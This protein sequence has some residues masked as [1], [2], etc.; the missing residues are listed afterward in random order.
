MM[1]MAERVRNNSLFFIAIIFLSP[2]AVT[3]TYV[4]VRIVLK[5]RFFILPPKKYL[6]LNV[7]IET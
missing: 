3:P 5:L 4:Q 6:S 1:K 2:T 7:N